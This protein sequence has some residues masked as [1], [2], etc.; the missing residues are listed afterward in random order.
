MEYYVKKMSVQRRIY[1]LPPPTDMSFTSMYRQAYLTWSCNIQ[2]A[3]CKQACKHRSKRIGRLP[4]GSR[5]VHSTV[6][7]GVGVST[8]NRVS[9]NNNQSMP[10]VSFTPPTAPGR[11]GYHFP[12][13]NNR[14]TT[15][16][17]PY[18][19]SYIWK[20]LQDVIPLR[21][22]F[23]VNGIQVNNNHRSALLY[24]LVLAVNTPPTYKGV[25]IKYIQPPT[26]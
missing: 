20:G 6:R 23:R 13:R 21:L 15:D 5:K 12:R 3:T 10:T 8:L 16:L 22:I 14:N 25:K 17:Q 26:G 9:T 1:S 4:N 11:I 24:P 7:F 2:E 19:I 18:A